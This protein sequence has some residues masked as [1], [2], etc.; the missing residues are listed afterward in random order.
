M[1][2]W[3]SKS[4]CTSTN[5]AKLP[6]FTSST[7]LFLELG[8]SLLGR[9]SP[10]ELLEVWYEH[11]VDRNEVLDANEMHLFLKAISDRW[12]NGSWKAEEM[13]VDEVEVEVEVSHGGE[14]GRTKTLLSDNTNNEPSQK[15]HGS[16]LSQTPSPCCTWEMCRYALWGTPVYG[17]PSAV[18][19]LFQRTFRK[20]CK[21]GSTTLT[22]VEA[23]DLARLLLS[24]ANVGKKDAKAV[25][26]CL[27][28]IP[29]PINTTESDGGDAN[30]RVALADFVACVGPTYAAL[31]PSH[32][33]FA[34]LEDESDGDDLPSA[35]AKIT[36]FAPARD[37]TQVEILNCGEAIMSAFLHTMK[38]AT[39]EIVMSWWEFTPDLPIVR[40]A[41]LGANAW[42]NEDGTLPL[43]LKEKAESGV[44]IYILLWDIVDVFM[45]TAPLVEHAMDILG[46]LHPNITVV[47]HPGLNVWTHSHHQKFVVADRRVAVLGGLDLTLRRYDTPEHPIFDPDSAVHPGVDFVS[48]A[49]EEGYKDHI[50]QYFRDKKCDVTADRPEIVAQPWQDISVWLEGDAAADVALNFRQRWNWTRCD[51]VE[52]FGDG[53]R[54]DMPKMPKIIRSLRKP[55]S[56]DSTGSMDDGTRQTLTPGGLPD[57]SV[58]TKPCK[59]QIV[60]SLGKWSGGLSKVEISHYEAWIVAIGEAK[61]Y[62]Y[63]EQQYFTSNMG[64]GVAKNRV[65]EAILLK[66]KEAIESGRPFRIYV[67]V[68]TAVATAPVAYYT[69]TTLIQD[70]DDG[71]ELCLMTRIGVLLKSAQ[72]GSYWYGKGA[73]SM[74][75]V[76]S[77]FSV[78]QNTSG[79]WDVAE[80]FVHSKVLVVDDRVAVI[81][82]ANVN[83]RSFVGFSDSEIGAIMWDGGDGSIREF[84]LRLWRQFLGLSLD[85]NMDGAVMDPGSDVAFDAWKE[86]AS[87]NQTLLSSVT[88]FTPR[89][90]ITSFSQLQNLKKEYNASSPADKAASFVEPERLKGMQGQL[91]KFPNKFLGDQK[92]RSLT[93]KLVDSFDLAKPVFL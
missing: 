41:S 63:I 57:S 59:V 10:A 83:D 11:D 67:V 51:T 9:P 68:P 4:L 37:N 90:S 50:K 91:V 60:R 77:L 71:Q 92:K 19:L 32:N 14:K 52:V 7:D 58:L 76:C 17:V 25:S 69:R 33:A 38:N 70:G 81:G 5:L 1:G 82:S 34:G 22:R 24:S 42:D 12:G 26:K 2:N 21:E 46:K 13:V 30:N 45:S 65:A 73:Q 85:G 27:L 29:L 89:D 80:I 56:S 72:Q 78:D 44:K 16:M 88:S 6:P 31:S 20:K 8:V 84:R 39:T 47:S 93:T 62:I 3:K 36:S 53:L 35:V 49:T 74:M 66:A 54:N 61:D 87:G 64:E 79:R 75:S 28:A 15:L 18:V 55:A 40:N 48:A 23:S 86:V 43:L